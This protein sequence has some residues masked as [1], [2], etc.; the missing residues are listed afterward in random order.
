M[1]FY[2]LFLLV[3]SL[4]KIAVARTPG[5]LNQSTSSHSETKA[6]LVFLQG[7]ATNPETVAK[8]AQLVK[9]RF[10]SLDVLIYNSG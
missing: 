3:I 9:D 5:V 6:Q 10:G 4:D 7:D 8:C 1:F 2:I